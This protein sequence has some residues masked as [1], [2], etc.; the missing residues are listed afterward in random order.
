MNTVQN[1]KGDR[2]RNNFGSRWYS[3]YAAIDW[4]GD[5][6]AP[7]RGVASTD[8]SPLNRQDVD[9]CLES[10]WRAHRIDTGLPG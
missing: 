1:G 10:R 5:R 7:D 4:R 6:C 8:L 3:G 9:E 2:P